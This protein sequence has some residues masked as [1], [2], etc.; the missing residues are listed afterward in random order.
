[1]AT[2]TWLNLKRDDI[3]N[4]IPVYGRVLKRQYAPSTRSADQQLPRSQRPCKQSLI[5]DFSMKQTPNKIIKEE[6]VKKEPAYIFSKGVRRK[7]NTLTHYDKE[8]FP[9][10]VLPLKRRQEI[11]VHDKLEFIDIDNR[12]E[13]QEHSLAQFSNDSCSKDELSLSCDETLSPSSIPCYS[14]GLNDSAEVNT[15]DLLASLSN[16]KKL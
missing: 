13:T 2:G 5:T 16:C 4:H 15:N 9:S 8:N 1:M 11:S 3:R 6:V 10:P 12:S 7:L 14:M